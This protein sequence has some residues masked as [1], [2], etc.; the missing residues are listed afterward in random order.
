[1]KNPA[2]GNAPAETSTAPPSSSAAV[3]QSAQADSAEVNTADNSSVPA[4]MKT[5]QSMS[6]PSV[7]ANPATAAGGKRRTCSVAPIPMPFR[8]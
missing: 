7:A 2:D 5:E 8:V 1:M 3:G 4:S 6:N